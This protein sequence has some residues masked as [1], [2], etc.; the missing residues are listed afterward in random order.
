MG[1]MLLI[2]GRKMARDRQLVPAGPD[3][4]AMHLQRQKH[5]HLTLQLLWEKYKQLN[6]SDYGYSRFC[7]MYQR[8]RSKLDVVLRQE[9][10]AGEKMFV[11]W[12]GTTVSIHDSARGFRSAR[13]SVRRCVGRQ[14][15]Y[16]RR[17]DER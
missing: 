11:D 7:E 9:H 12:A 15:L 5:R 2:L 13:A 1:L 4:A 10:K 8:W 14:L 3:F 17:S 6:P 16:L